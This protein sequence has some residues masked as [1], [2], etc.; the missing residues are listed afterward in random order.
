M[1]LCVSQIENNATPYRFE[2]TGISI[3]SFEEALYHGL[4]HFR[5]SMGDV[6]GEPFLKWLESI[7]LHKILEQMKVIAIMENASMAYLKFLSLTGYLPQNAVAN[8]KKELDDWQNRNEWERYK[9]QGDFWL[10]Q[11]N[12]EKAFEFYTLAL[13][14]HENAALLNNAGLALLHMGNAALSAEFF[15]KSADMEADNKQLRFN[16]IEALIAAELFEDAR[17]NL[18]QIDPSH[19]E[20]LYLMGR[21]SYA[22]RNYFEGIKLFTLA[23]QAAYDPDYIYALSDCYMRTRQFEKGI[24]ILQTIDEGDQD[25]A[26]YQKMANT[27]ADSGNVPAAIKT[28]EKAMMTDRSN[29]KLW[30]ALAEYYRKDYNLVRALGAIS[31]ALQLEPQNPHAILEQARVKKADGRIKDYQNSLAK[32]LEML[33]EEYRATDQGGA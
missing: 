21:I 23:L 15:G 24:A 7:G 4:H 28:I 9:E 22:Q 3:Y 27:Q 26:Y 29:V 11:K 14:H 12:G 20:A 18:A 25:L 8:L 2:M 5:Q 17:R 10:Q 1:H 33:K 30:I 13:K 31:K 32:I 16:H 19:P 6:F